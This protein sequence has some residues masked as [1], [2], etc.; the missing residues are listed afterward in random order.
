MPNNRRACGGDVV[1]DGFSDAG[2][3]QGGAVGTA[4][5]PAGV[6]GVKDANRLSNVTGVEP[7]KPKDAREWRYWPNLA[8]DVASVGMPRTQRGD[9]IF[10]ATEDAQAADIS[11]DTVLPALSNALLTTG[12]ETDGV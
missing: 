11:I 6:Y 12:A 7:A 8:P 3:F 1:N 2:G 4:Y 5:Y 9:P 10:S